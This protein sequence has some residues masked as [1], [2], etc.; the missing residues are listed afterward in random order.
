[1][2]RARIPARR[3]VPDASWPPRHASARFHQRMTRRFCDCKKCLS[4]ADF[5]DTP[6]FE[7][8]HPF[9]VLR[10][11]HQARRRADPSFAATDRATKKNLHN[12]RRLALGALSR[13]GKSQNRDAAI[14][15]NAIRKAVGRSENERRGCRRPRRDS[16]QRI[17][18]RAR[19]AALA[20][21]RCRAW[22]G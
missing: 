18:R 7:R 14:R 10:A 6:K 20:A 16:V 3:T 12:S 17:A 5:H 1:M 2:E 21:I 11:V 15:K 9:G 19:A 22:P 13:A 4:I 8:R